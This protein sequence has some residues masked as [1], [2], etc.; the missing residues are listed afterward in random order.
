MTLKQAPFNSFQ[1]KAFNVIKTAGGASQSAVFEYVDPG[2]FIYIH[3]YKQTRHR[4]IHTRNVYI[5]IDIACI[6]LK[7]IVYN[8]FLPAITD[9]VVAGMNKLDIAG[10]KLS[11]SRV[12]TSSAAM[13]LKPSAASPATGAA[14]VAGTGSLSL[15]HTQPL[16]ST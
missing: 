15:S 7:V 5:V 2:N 9:G 14:A 11:L 16:T 13:L 1:L 12:P 3:T 8:M 10:N 6:E 4:K